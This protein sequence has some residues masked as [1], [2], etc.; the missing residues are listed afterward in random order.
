VAADKAVSDQVELIKRFGH[1]GD[2]H[3]VLGINAKASEFHAAMGL[4]NLNYIDSLI[5]KRQTLTEMYDAQ[6]TKKFK[7]PVIRTG[8]VYN[9]A[10]YPILFESEQKLLEALDKLKEKEIYPRRYFYPS[11]NTLPYVDSGR[12]CP[13]SE[14]IAKRVV[15][16]PLYDALAEEDL[17]TICEE[18]IK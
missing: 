14:D 5:Q 11:L 8:T 4:C 16:L 1:Q 15:C 7:R 12:S 2:E 6:L 13:V 3:L 10:Y 18:L 17:K 9:F